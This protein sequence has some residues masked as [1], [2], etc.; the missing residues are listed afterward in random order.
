M[1][2]ALLQMVT[3]FGPAFATKGGMAWTKGA[4]SRH[5]TTTGALNGTVRAL[6]TACESARLRRA[7]AYGSHRDLYGRVCISPSPSRE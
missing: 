7:S 5:K 6:F 3:L 4:A 2:D 1:I